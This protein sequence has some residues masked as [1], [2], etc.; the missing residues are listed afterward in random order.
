MEKTNF[1]VG[2]E[3]FL[4]T[5]VNENW[6]WINSKWDLIFLQEYCPTSE[7]NL[8][9]SL[10]NLV[11]MQMIEACEAEDAKENRH[12]KTWLMVNIILSVFGRYYQME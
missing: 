3:S 5:A 8:V 10:M 7:T 4:K 1:L 2:L 9:V 6:F 12:L 11:D